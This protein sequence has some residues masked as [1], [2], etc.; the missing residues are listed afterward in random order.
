MESLASARKR[1]HR[2]AGSLGLLL[3]KNEEK[4]QYRYD[5]VTDFDKCRLHLRFGT[6]NTG[7]RVRFTALLDGHCRTNTTMTGV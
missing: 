1:V 7:G 5:V 6:T 2:G 3:E 4:Y